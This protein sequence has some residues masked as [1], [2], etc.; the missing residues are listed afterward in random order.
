M[1]LL[2]TARAAAAILLSLGALSAAEN[3]SPAAY[4]RQADAFFRNG[5]YKEAAKFWEKA[6]RLD[7]TNPDYRDNLGKAYE[8]LAEQSSFPLIYTSKARHSFAR[9]LALQPD[10]AGA[11]E[12]LI[13][14]AQQPVG[15]CQGDLT[16]ASNL[17]DR[18]EPVDPHA[19]QH[20]R[21]Y[22]NDA[23]DD[24]RRPAQ[25]VLCAPEK[26]ASAVTRKILPHTVIKAQAP[27]QPADVI[28]ARRSVQ[29]EDE[30]P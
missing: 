10:H 2:G 20:A 1:R 12:D 4:A 3:S 17:I 13:D 7:S 5:A 21:E 8:R 23:R 27:V 25:R 18:L 22:W 14:L 30:R 11:M 6:V 19:A 24:A 26:I 16:E 28:L 15:L 29:D 9:A